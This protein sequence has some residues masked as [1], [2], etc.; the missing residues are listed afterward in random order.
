MINYMIEANIPSDISIVSLE[1]AIKS[2]ETQYSYL[3]KSI[4]VSDTCSDERIKEILS[5][6]GLVNQVSYEISHLLPCDSWILFDTE[7]HG[8]F[9][10]GA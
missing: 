10:I 6:M 9:S 4:I 2:L 8:Y 1:H 3:P 7:G 5:V